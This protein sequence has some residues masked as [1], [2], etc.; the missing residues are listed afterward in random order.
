MKTKR[1]KN[2]D[3][4]VK[5]EG[6]L[7]NAETI[8]MLIEVIKRREGNMTKELYRSSEREIEYQILQIRREV[9]TITQI[10]SYVIDKD[11]LMYAKGV[12]NTVDIAETKLYE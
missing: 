11:N 2:H 5:L 4:R 1:E 3:L 12:I 6:Q 10:D 8:A 9:E 7:R